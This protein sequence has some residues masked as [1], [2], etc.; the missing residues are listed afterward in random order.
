MNIK[1]F[2]G[3]NPIGEARMHNQENAVQVIQHHFA[4][5]EVAL[6]Q[7]RDILETD[8]T[9]TKSSE[10]DAETWQQ[11]LANATHISTMNEWSQ[12]VELDNGK[13]YIVL[14]AVIANI[15]TKYC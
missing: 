11:V 13:F 4:E 14:V 10:R 9:S 15:D 8:D 12:F 2:D 6:S 5:E 7:I 1:N 3:K